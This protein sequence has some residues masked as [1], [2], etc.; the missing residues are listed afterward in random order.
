MTWLDLLNPIVLGV[1]IVIGSLGLLIL[2][3]GLCA[4]AAFLLFC[5]HLW[6]TFTE[7]WRA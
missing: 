1:C 6:H 2:G 3:L 7:A 5:R 4:L